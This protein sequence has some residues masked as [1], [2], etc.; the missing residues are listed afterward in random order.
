MH[1]FV[2]RDLAKPIYDNAL[3]AYFQYFTSTFLQS[4]FEGHGT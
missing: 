4:F 1:L 3:D 2:L